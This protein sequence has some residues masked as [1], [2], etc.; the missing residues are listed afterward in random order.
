M[1]IAAAFEFK[2]PNKLPVVPAAIASFRAPFPETSVI[3]FFTF[4]VNLF[5]VYN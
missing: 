5:N 1:P 4:T 2:N 3:K